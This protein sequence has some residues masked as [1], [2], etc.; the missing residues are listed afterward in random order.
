VQTRRSGSARERER[1][2]GRR[3]GKEKDPRN[4]IF[5]VERTLYP[6]VTLVLH[7]VEK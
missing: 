3:K 4:G 1:E 5:I 2:R 7:P 6:E